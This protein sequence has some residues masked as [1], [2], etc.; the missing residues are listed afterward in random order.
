MNGAHVAEKRSSDLTPDER[1]Q[2]EQATMPHL[3]AAYNLARWLTKD[4]HNAEDVVQEAYY[5]AARYFGSFRGGDGRAWLLSVVRRAAFDWLR[6]QKSKLVVVFNED[7]HD[8]GDEASNPELLAIQKCDQA[9][10]RQALEELPPQLR[11][12]IVLRELEGLSYQQI[13]TVIEIPMG[14]VMSRIA[15]GRQQLQVWLAA[16]SEGEVI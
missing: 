15:R 1:R 13:A 9:L 14:T 8:R 7:V 2:F 3:D 12:A 10:V 6:K 5:R 16:H 11:E 4:Q